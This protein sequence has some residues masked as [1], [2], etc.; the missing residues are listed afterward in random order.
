MVMMNREMYEKRMKD[1]KEKRELV[2][3]DPYRLAYHIQPPMGWLNDPNGLCQIDGTYHIYYQY[4]PF[5]P[6]GGTKLWGHYTTKDFIRFQEHEPFLFADT[7][8]DERGVYSG[9]AFVEDGTIYFFYTG[10]VKLFDRD[11]YDYCNN[12]REQNTILVTSQD[13]FHHTEKEWLLKN[14][15]YPQD[16]STHVRDP[17]ILKRKDTYYMV[18]GARDQ[19]SHG[20]LL[21][22]SSK[23]LRHWSLFDRL[24]IPGFGYMWECPDLFELDGELFLVFSPQG[25]EAQGLEYRNVYQT[26]YCKLELDFDTMEYQFGPFIELDRGFDY[27]A[28]Q[29]FLDE[30]GRRIQFGWM[31]MGDAPYTNEPTLKY[32]WQHAF[33]IPRQLHAKEGR[34]YQTPLKELEALRNEKK[35]FS[36]ENFSYAPET[37]QF[38]LDIHF[39]HSKPF[40]L[41][42]NEDIQ[43]SFDGSI[44][45]LSMKESGYGR[46]MRGI[47]LD[48]IEDLQIFIDAS[49]IEI[50]VNDGYT[51]FSSR[52]Y[53]K[54]GW[55][56]SLETEARG[57][58][59][60]YALNKIEV[61]DGD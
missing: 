50:F 21:I 45:S 61:S 13:G 24:S 16:M 33:T 6:K 48:A 17:K 18:L 49:S 53:P 56:L 10:N 31:G 37:K 2:K 25:L 8:A 42:L 60:Y 15:D 28:P 57:T 44:L 43:L 46:D 59:V 22:Y 5:E 12:G 39:D 32:E 29:S 14:S 36:F 54:E 27:Y 20:L 30:Q 38:E 4:S 3:N 55:K 23:D 58:I 7:R 9:S 19:D 11:D 41:H 47:E 34:L 26:G 52:A 35:E 51:V 1:E 40:V